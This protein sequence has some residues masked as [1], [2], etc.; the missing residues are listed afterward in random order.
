MKKSKFKIE[1]QLNNASLSILWNSI[2]TVHG[3][4]EW[5]ADEV[6]A[7]DNKFSFKWK[8]FEQTATLLHN[9]LNTYVRFQWD[10]DNGTDAYFELKIIPSE[11]SKDLMLQ[12]ID[13]AEPAEVDDT[14]MLWNK[15]VENL[16]RA[17][18]L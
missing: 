2:G 16:K 11:L 6:N 14:I 10:E 4:S 18:G 5:F 15:Q 7:E 13:F 9:R 17:T 8:D 3:L 12:V 1:Y